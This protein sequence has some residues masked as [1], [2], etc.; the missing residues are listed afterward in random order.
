M[1]AYAPKLNEV[2]SPSRPLAR[3]YI[4]LKYYFNTLERA[5]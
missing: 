4:L 5:S 1:V 3:Y 2:L